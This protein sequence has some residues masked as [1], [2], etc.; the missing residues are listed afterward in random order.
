MKWNNKNSFKI[1]EINEIKSWNI[2]VESSA[3]IDNYDN[4][5]RPVIE[6]FYSV[7]NWTN[8]Q[9]KQT[10]L[11]NTT[12]T[13]ISCKTTKHITN[14]KK[15]DVDILKLRYHSDHSRVIESEL[16]YFIL[17]CI[18]ISSWFKIHNNHQISSDCSAHLKNE[19]NEQFDKFMYLIEQSMNIR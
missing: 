9:S 2:L 14:N 16:K 12:T 10:G 11:S 15:K 6:M 17:P 19:L 8:N 5:W 7:N 18:H 4:Y 13:F 3:K 1:I